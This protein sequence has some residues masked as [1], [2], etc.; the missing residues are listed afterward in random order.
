[1]PLFRCAVTSETVFGGGDEV[2]ARVKVVTEG[3]E[4]GEGSAANHTAQGGNMTMAPVKLTS[5][6][7]CTDSSDRESAD[8][9][10]QFF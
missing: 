4:S 6:L 10:E 3:A 2:S 7:H 9:L 8:F 1:M 5:R